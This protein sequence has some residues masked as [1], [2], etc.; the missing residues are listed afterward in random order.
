MSWVNKNDL[1]LLEETVK[2]NFAARYKDSVIGIFWSVL[3][4]LLIMAMFTIIFS[5]IFG[6]DIDN[7][8]VYFLS[9]KCIF[10]LFSGT[11]GVSMNSIKMNK[12]ILQTTPAPKYIF[13][14][15]SILS[16]FL[17]FIIS[18]VLLFIIMLVTNAHFYFSI[19]P[20]A[21]IPILSMLI[22][23]TGLGFMLSIIG[24]YYADIQHLWSV[25]SMLLMY[26]SA[27]FYPMSIIPEPYHQYM[28]LNPVYWCI[29][30]FRCIIYQG[31]IPNGL[32]MFNSLLLSTIILVFG[33]II[34]KRYERRIS[35][36]F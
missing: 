24:V 5:T 13:I 23:V 32:Y 11:V 3:K 16:E 36:K 12:H 28:I 4:P 15:G 31:L 10:D 25:L 7:F 34:F 8:P 33:L 9:A 6:R 20:L 14:L 2:K 18:L 30:Q 27:L 26:G 35:M 1:F 21:I 22:M 19:M 29:D 17:N